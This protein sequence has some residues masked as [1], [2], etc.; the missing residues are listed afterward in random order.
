MSDDDPFTAKFS[1]AYAR[2]MFFNAEHD[3]SIQEVYKYV[4]KEHVRQAPEV[5]V[6]E[7]PKNPFEHLEERNR[8]LNEAR[9]EAAKRSDPTMTLVK[10]PYTVKETSKETVQIEDLPAIV[11]QQAE[12]S[13]LKRLRK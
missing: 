13:L 8:L 4:A 6:E 1:E 2:K 10:D 5:R 11:R 9:L 7:A 3:K 12:A